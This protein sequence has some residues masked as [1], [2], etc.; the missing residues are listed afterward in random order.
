M[1]RLG[2]VNPAFL[3]AKPAD[4][5]VAGEA[6]L[7]PL[8]ADARRSGTLKASNLGLG[9]WPREATR[10]LDEANI[11]EEEKW[12]ECVPLARLDL[13]HNEVEEVPR[14]V[15]ALGEALVSLSLAYNRV[16]SPLPDGMAEL[17]GLRSLDLS[18]NK[19][20][21]LPD[22]L[23]AGMRALKTLRLA[24]NRLE[25]LPRSLDAL[26]ALEEL[27]LDDNGLAEL[28][29]GVAGLAALRSLSACGNRLA[30]VPTPP[31]GLESLLVARNRLRA[32]P[33]LSALSRLAVVD[34]SENQLEALPFLPTGG[35]MR[36]LA[37]SSNRLS[38]LDGIHTVAGL[39]VVVVRGNRLASVPA[40]IAQLPLRI[41][42]VANN[43]LDDVP[44]Q[45]GTVRTLHKL[46]LEGNYLGKIRR[47]VPEQGITAVKRYLRE[48]L[49][50]PEASLNIDDMEE[51]D[52]LVELAVRD[53]EAQGNRLR[54]AGMGIAT[55]EGR[56]FEVPLVAVDASK[57]RFEE[58]PEGFLQLA[59][60][61]RKLVLDSNRFHAL[62][63]AP[64]F[65]GLSRL[66]E[67]R[68]RKN[69]LRDVPP[70][71]A[72]LPALRVVD[73]RNNR[74]EAFGPGLL[75][76]AQVHTLLLS[77]NAIT[78]V[79][80]AVSG[81]AELVE[82]DLG[83]NRVE[84]VSGAG[85]R[86]LTRLRTLNLEN[87][88]LTRLPL[89]MAVMPELAAVVVHGNPLR[90]MNTAVVRAGGGAIKEWL[91]KKIPDGS[92]LLA[93]EACDDGAA[94]GV[95]A[96]DYTE[97]D[98]LRAAIDAINDELQDFSLSSAKKFAVKKRL[99]LEKSKLIREERRIAKLEEE[100]AQQ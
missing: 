19:L 68:A 58:L 52:R 96:V 48:R 28:P 69:A 14:D 40:E 41:L 46:V 42:D 11:G 23:F 24:D 61:L 2:R 98:R 85:L 95:A 13:S 22:A 81:L 70:E 44:S 94:G 50:L 49:G 4:G 30:A 21:A 29:A 36:Q 6:R 80:E 63:P 35:S 18:H 39:G 78:E 51:E 60:S 5:V 97:R 75:A 31:R 25:R 34:A 88:S 72:S 54:V 12:W 33:D 71:L 100:A 57:N 67:L 7:A 86:R 43:A 99:A 93:G 76:L 53:A 62:G 84:D 47:G 10:L 79:P 8:Y 73:L 26:A 91:R 59:G 15:G 92:P 45:L 77:F 3:S 9:E 1:S 38:S 82:L 66:A 74:I 83:D 32:L 56:A 27:L 64:V 65:G 16:R 87:N 55:L 37:L 17:T 90:A 20:D 89:E